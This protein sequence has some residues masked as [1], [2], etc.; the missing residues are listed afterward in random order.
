V[1]AFNV[2]NT[3]REHIFCATRDKVRAKNSQDFNVNAIEHLNQ[4]PVRAGM[5]DSINTWLFYGS[6]WSNIYRAIETGVPLIPTRFGPAA[7]LLDT[8]EATNEYIPCM[9]CESGDLL[10]DSLCVCK[11]KQEG[12]NIIIF[13]TLVNSY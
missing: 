12:K 5:I 10:T 2:V 1:Q 6:S 9:K 4:H 13:G 11:N 7:I 3:Q 8:A